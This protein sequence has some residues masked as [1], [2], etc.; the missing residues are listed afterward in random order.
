MR[1]W[2]AFV[3]WSSLWA[4][5][6]AFQ[7]PTPPFE[8]LIVYK[9]KA[10]GEAAEILKENEPPTEM[11]LYVKGNRF[12]VN[13]TG[14]SFPI[15]RLYE[16][17]SDRVYVL[18]PRLQRAFRS[19]PYRKKPKNYPAHYIGDTLRILGK[20]CYAFQ[21]KKPNEEII[22]YVAPEYRVDVSAFAGKRRAYAFFLNEGL[23]G[24]IPLKMI[25][26]RKD[27]TIEVVA[28]RIQA[29]KLDAESLRIPRGYQIW[30][31]DYRR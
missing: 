29:M 26:K 2:W 14:G 19:E 12:L 15:S 27:M 28:V 6:E 10:K 21:V 8:G 9:V 22:Y 24:A 13:E 11:Q 7:A 20:L 18:D 5:S 16:P 17:D 3:F 4:Q 31:Y 1:R 25:R 30:G 23:Y